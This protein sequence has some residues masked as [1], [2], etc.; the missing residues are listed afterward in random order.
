MGAFAFGAKRIGL[1][2]PTKHY[3]LKEMVAVA[4][5]VLDGRHED[6]LE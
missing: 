4:T 5:F 2:V 1:L 6:I 3:R